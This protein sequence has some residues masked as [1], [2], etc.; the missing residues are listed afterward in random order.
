VSWN[1][2]TKTSEYYALSR[3]QYV[4]NS[5]KKFNMADCKPKRTPI[6]T[7]V[8]LS[9][10]DCPQIDEEKAEMSIIPYREAV[11]VLMYLM[12]C[13]RP[14]IATAVGL[15][16]RFMT[17]PGR[18]HW[19]AVKRIFR[20]LQGTKN[21]KL[22]FNRHMNI[23]NIRLYAYADADWA[24]NLVDRKSTSGCVVFINDMIIVWLSKK[25]ACVAL[26]TMEA[27][28]VAAG[29]AT[30]ELLWILQVLKEF[31]LENVEMVLFQDN[32]SCVELIKNPKCTSKSKHIQIRHHFIQ[33][34][35]KKEKLQVRYCKSK[36]MIADLLTK[37]QSVELF[38]SQRDL[39][40]L[41]I[42]N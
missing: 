20:Y 36:E 39:L 19:I 2:S 15:V 28:Y 34:E 12:V 42:L 1:E 21:L 3:E 22:C 5:L 8:K 27:E 4:E 31:D 33:D 23:E 10:M 41:K 9:L 35:V 18:K 40:G 24:G 14:D 37:G 30:Q 38:E 32:T 26:S 29:L 7:S 6:D 11:G 17:N 25:Q 16:S 13:S